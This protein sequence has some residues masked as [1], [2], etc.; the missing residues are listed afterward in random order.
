MKVKITAKG[1]QIPTLVYKHLNF[2]LQKISQRLPN[3]KYDLALMTLFIRKT[4]HK[5]YSKRHYHHSYTSY[6][7]RRLSL[8]S[9]EG[10]MNL[11]LPKKPLIITFKGQTINECIDRGIDRLKEE[12]QKYKDTHFKSQSEYPNRLSIRVRG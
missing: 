1:F 8:A 2:H 9:Y 10:S 6:A 12:L 11:R 7:D 4:T 5:Y 3:L